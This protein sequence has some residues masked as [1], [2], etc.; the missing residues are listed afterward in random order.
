MSRNLFNIRYSHA[1]IEHTAVCVPCKANLFASIKMEC[2][3]IRGAFKLNCISDN[4]LLMVITIFFNNFPFCSPFYILQLLS[5]SNTGQR[6]ACISE[7]DRPILLLLLFYIEC[8]TFASPFEYNAVQFTRKKHRC[9]N[10]Y[11]S[12]PLIIQLS[13]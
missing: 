6:V 5:L 11:C 2:D 3:L 12:I 9:C 13:K 7:H 4:S 1:T 10:S 8:T